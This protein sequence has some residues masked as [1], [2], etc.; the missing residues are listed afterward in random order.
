LDAIT[1]TWSQAFF[2]RGKKV[3][4]ADSDYYHGFIKIKKGKLDALLKLGGMA[5]FYPGPRSPEKGPDPGFRSILLRGHT[6]RLDLFRLPSKF[7]WLEQVKA[8]YWCSNGVRVLATEY[9]ALKKKVFPQAARI[10]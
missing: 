6:K 2:Q 1:Q 4:A 3:P 9:R 7:N 10:K 5:G 8:W